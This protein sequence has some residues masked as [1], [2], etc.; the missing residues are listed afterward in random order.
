[1]RK[2]ILLLAIPLLGPARPDPQAEARAVE[3]VRHATCL[4]YYSLEGDVKPDLLRRAV[5]GLSTIEAEAKIA[6]GPIGVSSKPKFR[7]VA[8]ELPIGTKP[9]EVEKALRQASPKSIELAWTS[10]Q[11]KDRE[12]PSILGYNGPECVVGMD[13]DMRWFAL[14]NG[15]ARFFYVRGK[16]D[17][18]ELRGRFKTLYKPFDADELGELVHERIEWKLAEPLDPAAGKAA[19][20]ALLKVPG[21]AKAKVDAAARTLTADIAHDGLQAAAPP[22]ASGEKVSAAGVPAGGF[23][24]DDALDALGAAKVNVSGAAGK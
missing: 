12:L 4:R 21:V 5:A 11:G 24:A 22:V 23:L 2:A 3:P 7:F 13:N 1:M 17:E 19:E 20:K 8:L 15:L 18:A 16:L 9:K 14:E 6:M 10:F